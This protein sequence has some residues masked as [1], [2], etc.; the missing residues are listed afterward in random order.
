MY[1]E[2]SWVECG[3][4]HGSTVSEKASQSLIPASHAT[5]WSLTNRQALYQYALIY[6]LLR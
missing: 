1:D 3:S 2:A 6:P 4:P 5:T